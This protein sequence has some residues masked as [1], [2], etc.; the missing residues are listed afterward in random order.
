MIKETTHDIVAGGIYQHYSGKQYRVIGV[1]RHSESLDEM[2][3][4][5]SLYNNS[6]GRLWC[7]P[8][9]MWNEIVEVDGQKVPRFKFLFK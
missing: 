2:V 9:P 4:Y 3:F 7:R 5:E 6:V 1:G 8:L